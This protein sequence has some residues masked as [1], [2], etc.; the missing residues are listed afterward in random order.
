MTSLEKQQIFHQAKA[1]S[2]LH[3]QHQ[4]YF[5]ALRIDS[6]IYILSA[7]AHQGTINIIQKKLPA[8]LLES[9]KVLKNPHQTK[10][11]FQRETQNSHWVSS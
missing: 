9:K 7:I 4:S 11:L 6:V 1:H 2:P 8:Q 5:T 10:A 3:F